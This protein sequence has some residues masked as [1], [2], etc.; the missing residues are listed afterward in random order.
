MSNVPSLLGG[1]QDLQDQLQLP[2]KHWSLKLGSGTQDVHSALPGY[3]TEQMDMRLCGYICVAIM[4]GS[5]E[6]FCSMNG[7]QPIKV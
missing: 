6:M 2:L 3:L 5:W 4:R 1:V 7:P